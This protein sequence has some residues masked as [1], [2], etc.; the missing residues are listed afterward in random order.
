MAI[1]CGRS[2]K[3][4]R[5]RHGMVLMT[6]EGEVIERAMTLRFNAS[7]NEAEY[8]ALRLDSKWPEN[9]GSYG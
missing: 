6:P 2:V 8:E 5:L 3:F 9:S 4:S 1:I 7:N